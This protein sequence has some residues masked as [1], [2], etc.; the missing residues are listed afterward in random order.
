MKKILVAGGA[1]FIGSYLCERLL[2]EGNDVVCL[3]NLSTG[4]MKN[5]EHLLD[6]H[7]FQFIRQDVQIPI[8]FHVDEIYNLA[9]PSSMD[10]AEKNG[11]DVLKTLL[12]GSINLLELAKHSHAKILL[13]SSDSV[14]GNPSVCPQSEAYNGS[15]NTVGSF[16]CV[17]EGFRCAESLFSNYANQYGLDIRIARLF[18]TYG[19]RMVVDGKALISNFVIQALRGQDLTVYG[20]GSQI[21]SLQYVDD[22]VQGLFELMNSN[23]SILDPINIGSPE[24]TSISDVANLIL[25]LTGSK[26]KISFLPDESNQVGR[27][28][29]DIQKAKTELKTWEAVI[30]IKDGLAKTI[31]YFEESLRKPL[32]G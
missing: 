27:K 10:Y 26:S 29:P 28:C 3:D 9:C 6:N 30:P 17:E 23:D 31:V 5:I 12:L 1:G 16:S 2:N 20:D 32:R 7:F 25:D 13:A 24:E 18:S 14:Y 21:R 15:V 19:P 22:A 11:V 8:H 4:S